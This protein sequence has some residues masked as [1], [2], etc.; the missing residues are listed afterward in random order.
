VLQSCLLLAHSDVRRGAKKCLLLGVYR[1]RQ[2]PTAAFGMGF[3]RR[4]MEAER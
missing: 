2:F 1:P 3:N 4:K